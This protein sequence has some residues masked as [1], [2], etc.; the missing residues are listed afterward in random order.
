MDVPSSQ[1]SVLLNST[2][3]ETTTNAVGGTPASHKSAILKPSSLLLQ[4]STDQLRTV[5]SN[6]TAFAAGT[7]KTGNT[8]Q[9]TSGKPANTCTDLRQI[10]DEK[11]STNQPAKAQPKTSEAFDR[12]A[13]AYFDKPAGKIDVVVDNRLGQ[14]TNRNNETKAMNN[15]GQFRFVNTSKVNTIEPEGANKAN[16]RRHRSGRIA[17][18]QGDHA[19]A[20]QQQNAQAQ[21]TS[22]PVQNKQTTVAGH[23]NIQKTGDASGNKRI[24]KQIA[25][26]S[27]PITPVERL[28]SIRQTGK[29]P[30][31]VLVSSVNK[32]RS[33][34]VGETP[35]E[36]QQTPN[37]RPNNTKGQH[38][39]ANARTFTAVVIDAEL[40]VAIA[41]V[42]TMGYIDPM[43]QS[44][45][46]KVY[47]TMNKFMF[48]ELDKGNQMPT[49][50]ENRHTQG[51]MK[52]R[53]TS[54]AVKDWLLREV[55]HFPKLWKGINLTVIGFDQLP[56]PK[57]ILGFFK[58]C[59]AS[60]EQILKMLKAMNSC[61]YTDRWTVIRRS[62]SSKGLHVSFGVDESQLESLKS[63]N[64]KL[65]FGAGMAFF[66]DISKKSGRPTANS[67]GDAFTSGM[68]TDS[69]ATLVN[70]KIATTTPQPPGN[71]TQVHGEETLMD[72]GSETETSAAG[73]QQDH[74]ASGSQ[75]NSPSAQS[76]AASAETK[77]D[78]DQ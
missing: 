67:D 4:T 28:E 53:C 72:L 51:V 26:R 29:I 14:M 52:I 20:H 5:S 69:E 42:S 54:S 77:H 13:Q 64:Y 66:R 62:Q 61:A 16:K 60:N 49:F 32:K 24:L 1:E 38:N 70:D 11:T 56:K 58:Q 25:S 44:K 37:R 12:A 17:R 73:K 57:K 76:K 3:D 65:F 43:D 23:S 71:V 45:Y 74:H 9:R 41:D 15:T 50:L 18:E 75:A 27:V 7:S 40:T 47:E 19:R 39:D 48:A 8:A 35:P 34:I 46:E 21:S 68:D 59:T 22:T 55:P 10:L 6:N 31:P 36:V 30:T 63:C 2:D 78:A 33:R